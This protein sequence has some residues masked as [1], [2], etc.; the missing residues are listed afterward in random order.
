MKCSVPLRCL[1]IGLGLMLA[2]GCSM[3]R[4]SIASRKADSDR[5]AAEDLVEDDVSVKTAGTEEGAGPDDEG[6]L[7]PSQPGV[8]SS[9]GSRTKLAGWLKKGGAKS[10]SIPLD[11]TDKSKGRDEE[12]DETGGIW[13][14]TDESVPPPLTT[15]KKPAGK[16]ASQTNDSSGLSLDSENPFDQ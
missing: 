13:N 2:S 3:T 7:P 4:G 11:R 16:T 9:G 15:G 10:G 5:R 1:L 8:K 12:A 6:G 14:H